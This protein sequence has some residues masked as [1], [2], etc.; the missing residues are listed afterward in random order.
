MN[1]EVW[2]PHAWFFIQTA[3]I[4]MPDDA[5]PSHYVNFLFSLQYVLP[6]EKCRANYSAWIRNNPI[7]TTKNEMIRW[8]VQLQNSIREDKCK[9]TRS[10]EEVVGYYTI[11]R[12]NTLVV[13]AALVV[14]GIVVLQMQ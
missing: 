1:A 2:G 7:P 12:M 3:L 4:Y 10:I 9:S 13:I 5:D 11:P 6:C 14:L 8:I